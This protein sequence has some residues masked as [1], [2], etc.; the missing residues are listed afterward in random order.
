M[1]PDMVP[2]AVALPII[3]SARVTVMRRDFRS[4]LLRFPEIISSPRRTLTFAPLFRRD[5]WGLG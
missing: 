4:L 1:D 3:D 2:K 5:C